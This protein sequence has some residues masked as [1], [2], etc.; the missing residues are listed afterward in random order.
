[1]SDFHA[2]FAPLG[3]QARLAAQALAQADSALKNRV[4][5]TMAE[6]ILA[7]RAQILAVNAEDMDTARRKG[8]DQALLERLALNEA[9]IDSMADGIRQIAALPDPVGEIRHLRRN[10]KG[11]QI[12]RMRVP[13]GVIGIIY[14]SRPNVTADAAALCLKAGNAAILR[15][16]SEALNSNLAIY[17]AI[18]DALV[19]H[20]LPAASVQ[21]ID[22][23]DRGWVGAMLAA[24]QAIDVIIPRGGKSLVKRVAEEARMPVIK[25]L[26]GICHLYVD[27][28]ADLELAVR[29]A[30]NGKTYRYGICGATETLL[31]HR[32][33][34]AAFLPS[35]A[36]VYRA[37]GVEMR[38]CEATRAILGDISAA[39]ES[40]WQTEYLDAIISIKIVDDLNAACAHIARYGSQHTDSIATQDLKRAQ[41][42]LRRVDSASVMVNTPTCFADGYEYGLGAEIGISTDKIHWRGPVGVEG[43]TAEKFIVLSDGVTR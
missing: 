9:R 30:D 15:G 7:A 17:A 29:I 25:H 34:A 37:K 27:D 35:I 23:A 21:L 18:R 28:T 41:E 6:N 42:F 32:D 5:R 40:D 38:G 8:L 14:E 39:A 1:M 24:D 10:E 31:V 33:I 22:A 3:A 26:D 13:L 11:L 2:A 16:G 4:L 43:L 12:G 36:A 19:A 20:G